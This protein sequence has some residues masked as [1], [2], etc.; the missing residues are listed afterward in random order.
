MR[1]QAFEQEGDGFQVSLYELESEF[2]PVLGSGR[3]TKFKLIIVSLEEITAR[4][5]SDKTYI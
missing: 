5:G 3:G 1:N 4:L 2:N